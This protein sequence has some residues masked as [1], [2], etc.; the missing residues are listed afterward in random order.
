[1][2]WALALLLLLVAGSSARD[3]DQDL[4]DTWET[5]GGDVVRKLVT[6]LENDSLA[7]GPKLVSPHLHAPAHER[8]ENTKAHAHVYTQLSMWKFF[9]TR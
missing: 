8:H 4:D 9:L 6:D 5:V 7:A 1:L 2:C 3:L